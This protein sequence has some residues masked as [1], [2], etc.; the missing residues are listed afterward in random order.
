MGMRAEI[1]ASKVICKQPGRYIGW[2]CVTKTPTGELLAV[3]SGDRDAH[4]DPFGKTFLVRSKDNGVTWSEPELVN[5]T[6]LDDRDA[7]ICAFPD[8]AV[9]VSWFTSHYD[10]YAPVWTARS[11]QWSLRAGDKARWDAQLAKVGREQ[12]DAWTQYGPD[13]DKRWM[14]FWT[15]LSPDGGRTWE[16]PRPSPCSAPNGPIV[17]ADG[18]LLYV[19]WTA[20]A[21]SGKRPD[22]KRRLVVA[23]SRDRGATWRTIAEINASP[24]Y[25]GKAPG[26]FSYLGEPHVVETASG[27]L[28]AMARYEEFPR[29]EER[30]FL[31]Q[32][33]S[34]D[35]GHTWTEPRATP[36]WGKPPHLLRLRD[37]RLLVSYGI[38]RAPFGQRA[39]L[40]RDDGKT[41]DYANEIVLRDDAPNGDLGYPASVQLDD[42]TLLTVYYQRDN[43]TEKPCLMATH[44]RLPIG[45]RE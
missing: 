45:Q 6:P 23:E 16:A 11:R 42:D 7:G 12:I 35:G 27:K 9:L 3:F 41:W 38:R 5:D 26:G 24:D 19:G 31:W 39:C 15:R 18:R 22:A 44:W 1:I 20:H 10:D 25:P 30:C 36:I 21:V 28:V 2:P 40:S 33:E 14:G 29:A 37:G 32:F 43:A 8:G 13:Q 4:V 17:L 34:D